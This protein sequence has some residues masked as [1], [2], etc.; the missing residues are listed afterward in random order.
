MPIVDGEFD[1]EAELQRW[2]KA[3]VSVF[4]QDCLFLDGFRITTTAG[5][6]GVPDGFALNFKSREWYIIESEL[7]SHGVWPHIAGDGKGTQLFP[8][9]RAASPLRGFPNPGWLR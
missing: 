7:L 6:G 3:N 8:G 5:K 2:V 1:N 4:L 9:R